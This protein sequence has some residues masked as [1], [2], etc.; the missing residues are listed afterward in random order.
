ML[1]SL[2]ACAIATMTLQAADGWLGTWKFDPS[3][4]QFVNVDAYKDGVL[5]VTEEGGFHVLNFTMTRTDGK[6]THEGIRQPIGGGKLVPIGNTQV[7]SG[8]VEI[9]DDHE[10]VYK[11]YS[12]DGKLQGTRYVKLS[13]DGKEQEADM[14]GTLGGKNF[15]EHEVAVKQ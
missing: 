11:Y 9:A 12:K 14:R 7:Q 8:V 3:R 1:K 10:W 4:A 2:V 13:K 6:V 15:V 5:V